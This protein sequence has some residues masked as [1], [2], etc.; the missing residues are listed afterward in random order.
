MSNL[1]SNFSFVSIS[2]VTTFLSLNELLDQLGF[3]TWQTVINTFIL[4]PINL[5]GIIC[6]SFSLWIFFR[7]SFSD[8]IFFYFKR[9]CFLNIQSLLLNIPFGILISPLYFPWINTY[10]SSVFQIFYT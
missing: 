2:N 9:L 1:S 4:P 8:P 3:E 5:I 7:P 6:C 10:A